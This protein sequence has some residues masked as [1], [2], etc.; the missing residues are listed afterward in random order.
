LSQKQPAKCDFH[1]AAIVVY[2]LLWQLF[3]QVCAWLSQALRQGAL[4]VAGQTRLQDA[5][6]LA[7]LAMQASEAA[8]ANRNLLAPELVPAE[9]APIA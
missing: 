3:R 7:Q 2:L 5:F 8:S 1:R 9:A 6:W 4:K